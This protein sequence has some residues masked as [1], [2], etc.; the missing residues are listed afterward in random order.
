MSMSCAQCGIPIPN[1]DS[2]MC[3]ICSSK[4]AEVQRL[5]RIE[6][7]E[8]RRREEEKQ[9]NKRIHN[10]YHRE[11]TECAEEVKLKAKKCIHCGHEFPDWEE[12]RAF[13]TMRETQVEELG[14]ELWESREEIKKQREIEIK[15][16]AD[17]KEKRELKIRLEER[18]F[19]E[20]RRLEEE[21]IAR[22]KEKWK[23]ESRYDPDYD[24]AKEMKKA[25]LLVCSIGIV[26][27]I[28]SL[29]S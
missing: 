17:L 18:N 7:A 12:K 26:F 22:L 23:K 19:E 15:K 21:E 4:Y 16:A 13:I 1:S 25:L 11:C 10:F 24:A 5:A 6:Q 20:K 14:C 2:L 28:L 27:L 9:R 8:N 29:F 3:N